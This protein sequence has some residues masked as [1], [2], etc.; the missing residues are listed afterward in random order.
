M[1]CHFSGKKSIN[2]EKVRL[3]GGESSQKQYFRYPGSVIN[4]DGVDRDDV[5]HRIKSG[6]VN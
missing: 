1:T 4:Q 5:N 2:A 3:N 6:R